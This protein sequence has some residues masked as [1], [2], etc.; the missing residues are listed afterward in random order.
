M[1]GVEKGE[2]DNLIVF[3]ADDDLVIWKNMAIAYNQVY[4]LVDE[5]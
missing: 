4:C 5:L 1:F 2:S 3:V